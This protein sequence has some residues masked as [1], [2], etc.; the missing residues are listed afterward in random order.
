M[1]I[2]H[3][4]LELKEHSE[5][6]IKDLF[7]KA[8]AIKN[9]QRRK[10]PEFF[11]LTAA[12]LFFESST[13]TR[14]SF[15][16][17]CARLGVYPLILSGAEGT[18]LIKGESI[19]DTIL[20]L[21]S[22][23]PEVFIVR[24]G[25]GFDL[26][27]IAQQ[28]GKVF[29]NAG[30]GMHGHPTQALLDCFCWQEYVSNIRGKKLLIVG[31]IKHSRV[32][33]SHRELA[34]ILGYEVAFCGPASFLPQTAGPIVFEKLSEG[35]QWADAV[36]ALRVQ[37]ERHQTKMTLDQYVAN[38][39]LNPKTIQGLSSSALIFHPGPVNYG[40]ELDLSIL[41]DSRCRILNQVEHGV[42]LRQALLQVILEESL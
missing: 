33:A 2:S 16:T 28:T 37:L 10:T 31:D 25:D 29:I 9:S 5:I 15:E 1:P 35:L 36:M 22:M 30:W 12:L 7:L 17:A 6:E 3:G 8:R 21:K 27:Q 18:S 42:W 13:R 38:Y 24:C 4:L 23:N 34:Q 40:I 14:F 32:A 19:E 11:G 20:N 41:K 39:Q 26:R